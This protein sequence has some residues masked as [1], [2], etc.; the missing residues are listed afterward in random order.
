[1][2]TGYVG[3]HL[4]DKG[5]STV[6]IPE[7]RIEDIVN[8]IQ[9]ANVYVSGA[10]KNLVIHVGS[11]NW[12]DGDSSTKIADDLCEVLLQ[13]RECLPQTKIFISGILDRWDAKEGEISKFNGAIRRK[14]KSMENVEFID[15][16]LRGFNSNSCLSKNGINPNIKGT[17][18]I[19]KTI[20]KN[21]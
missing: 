17:Q 12:A 16:N 18:A 8:V 3:R 6:C 2:M 9:S 10:L 11:N 14:L 19:C 15:M 5:L 21:L 7:A 13:A 1:M 4:S 20:S